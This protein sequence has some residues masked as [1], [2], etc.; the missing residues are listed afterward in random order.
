MAR[1]EEVLAVMGE[2]VNMGWEEPINA[3]YPPLRSL[4]IVLSHS[5]RPRVF[6]HAVTSLRWVRK[7]ILGAEHVMF[8]ESETGDGDAGSRLREWCRR[9][10]GLKQRRQRKRGLERQVVVSALSPGVSP[11]A[12][13]GST[14]RSATSRACVTSWLHCWSFWMTVSVFFLVSFLLRRRG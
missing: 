1:E 11:V 3:L 6:E 13:S 5:G 7:V 4:D 12:S 2:A 8:E 10:E 9:D 14:L